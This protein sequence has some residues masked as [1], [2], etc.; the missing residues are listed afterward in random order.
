MKILP[1]PFCGI[2]FN[3]ERDIEHIIVEHPVNECPLR[4]DRW[5]T[6]SYTESEIE[7][8][9]NMERDENNTNKTY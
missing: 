7:A 2:E 5:D 4:G 8:E 3:I 9:L 6:N 1:C